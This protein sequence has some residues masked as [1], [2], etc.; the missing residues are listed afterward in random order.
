MNRWVMVPVLVLLLA[1]PLYGQMGGGM[2]GGG[3]GGGGMMGGGYGT[4]PG[5]RGGSQGYMY[6]NQNQGA[7]IFRVNCSR[8][9]A[10]GGNLITPNLPLRG[11]PQ[12]TNFDTF[13]AFIRN[14][15]LPDGSSGPMPPFSEERVSDEQARELYGYLVN[16]F[17]MPGS[18]GNPQQAPGPGA[19]YGMGPGMT[20]RGSGYGAGPSGGP[21]YGMGGQSGPQYHQLQKPLSEEQARQEV[22]GYMKS[23]GNPNLKL[24]KL[25]DKGESWEAEIVTKDGSLVDKILVNKSGGGMRSIY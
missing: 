7:E 8:C 4:G 21:G 1:A 6:Q 3:M 22:E 11:A 5:Q 12:L 13:L 16:W 17:G 14:P 24:G 25:E 10:D 23:M 2:M 20:G 18:R 9:H 15:R 19:G